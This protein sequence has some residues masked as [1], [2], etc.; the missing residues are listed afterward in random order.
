MSSLTK[1]DRHLNSE[2]LS[3]ERWACRGKALKQQAPV[4]Q[5][6]RKV[7]MPPVWH[8]GMYKILLMYGSL[9]YQSLT[10]NAFSQ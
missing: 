7:L 8:K 5:F 3:I 6:P 1:F 10:E 4:L 9:W 2:S